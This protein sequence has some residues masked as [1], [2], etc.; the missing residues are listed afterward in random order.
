MIVRLH[1]EVDNDLLEAMNYYERE[2][3]SQLA[4]EFYEEFRRCAVRIGTHPNS[5]PRKS[6][7]L[8][9]AN[10]YRFPY[11]LLFEILDMDSVE[12]LVVKHDHRR[13]SYGTRR[14]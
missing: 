6:R 12:I 10:F 9:R 3:G 2:A 8:R 7:R 14:R 5:F 13:P 1:P 11:H 4:L